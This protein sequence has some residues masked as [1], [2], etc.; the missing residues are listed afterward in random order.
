MWT[1]FGSYST[2]IDHDISQSLVFYFIV[3]TGAVHKVRHAI[4]GQ[5]LPPPSVTLCNTSRNPPESTSHIS[6]PRPKFLV[7]LVQK[8]GQKPPVQILSQLFTRLFVR[9][10]L[11]R[12]LLSG[13]RCPR[14]FLSVPP[15][16]R[17]HMLQ[18]KVKH[19]SSK[20]YWDLN[21]QNGP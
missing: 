5:F 13:R 7:G 19:Q 9:G 16:V 4:F 6:D 11:S 10:F 15:S 12:G 21:T 3:D 20:E 1:K 17:I 8:R 18:Q 14:W 2:S